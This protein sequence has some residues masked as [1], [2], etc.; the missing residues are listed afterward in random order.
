M[1]EEARKAREKEEELLIQQGKGPKGKQ[2]P[3]KP[4]EKKEPPKDNKKKEVKKKDFKIT[5]III[6]PEPQPKIND[7]SFGVSSFLLA[8]LLK[9]HI[10]SL[11][12]RAPIVPNKKFEVRINY[13]F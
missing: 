12:L 7:G 5:D 1:D 6:E 2:A 3:N 11:K 10:R 8:D 4:P 9:N 13:F